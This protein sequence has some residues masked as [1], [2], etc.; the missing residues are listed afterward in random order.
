MAEGTT[1]L[2]GDVQT[3]CSPRSLDYPDHSKC[4][5]CVDCPAGFVKGPGCSMRGIEACVPDDGGCPLGG[6]C[7][8]DGTRHLCPVG[9]WGRSDGAIGKTTL[10][11]ACPNVC[12]TDLSPE[13]EWV[14]GATKASCL[15]DGRSCT[16]MCCS[17]DLKP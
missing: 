3:Y 5:V 16:S 8:G 10:A 7:P 11:D 4:S 2:D 15:P 14:A 17:M 12:S 1:L 13:S 9:K 6:W